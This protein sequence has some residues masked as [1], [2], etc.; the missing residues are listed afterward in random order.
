MDCSIYANILY[1]FP[2][3]RA[4]GLMAGENLIGVE[5]Q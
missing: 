2:T 4:Q 1:P 3:T 5:K